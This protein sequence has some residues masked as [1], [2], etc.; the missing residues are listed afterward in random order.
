[1]S[2]WKSRGSDIADKGYHSSVT[3]ASKLKG[4]FRYE[5]ASKIKTTRTYPAINALARYESRRYRGAVHQVTSKN[6]GLLIAYLLPGFTALWGVSYFSPTVHSWMNATPSS[7][8][9]I[10]GFLYVT[11]ASIGA[12]LTVSTVRWALIDTIHHRTGIR[13]PT[14]DFSQLEKNLQAYS[15]LIEIHYDYYKFYGNMFIALFVAYFAR[16]ASLGLW[17]TPVGA[18]ELATL[19]L[20]ILFFAGSRDTL[21]KY[22]M[23]A[24]QS[25]AQRSDLRQ[26]ES[27]EENSGVGTTR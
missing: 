2:R 27:L 8:A 24:G 14:W 9:T 17:T 5:C 11:L 22:Y 19:L 4:K 20:L 6:F 12:G 21:S 15:R 1:M 25:L 10:G 23:R 26:T 3:Q 13:Q 16:R 7:P 18:N